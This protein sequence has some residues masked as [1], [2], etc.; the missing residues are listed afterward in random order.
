MPVEK[1]SSQIGEHRH[2][3]TVYCPLFYVKN[4]RII[5]FKHYACL[6]CSQISLYSEQTSICETEHL[7][8]LLQCSKMAYRRIEKHKKWPIFEQTTKTE[9]Q[10][11][12]SVCGCRANAPLEGTERPSQQC[13]PT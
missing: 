1:P 7:Y 12:A 4:A 6:S 10:Y 2:K 13:V 8:N 5:I 9:L 3:R 11:G